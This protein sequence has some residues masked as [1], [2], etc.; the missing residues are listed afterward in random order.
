MAAI[1][2][3]EVLSRTWAVWSYGW[4]SW[5]KVNI[6]SDEF[7]FQKRSLAELNPKIPKWAIKKP[8]MGT[9]TMKAAYQGPKNLTAVTMARTQLKKQEVTDTFSDTEDS[10]EDLTKT[11]HINLLKSK[12]SPLGQTH[13]DRDLTEQ[14]TP[15]D[16]SADETIRL[17]T[18]TYAVDEGPIYDPKKENRHVRSPLNSKVTNI[19]MTKSE[20]FKQDEIIMGY[21][22]SH[23][24]SF[25]SA[26]PDLDGPIEKLEKGDPEYYN[27]QPDEYTKE[28]VT[29]PFNDEIS[30]IDMEPTATHV[31]VTSVAN[32]FTKRV[33]KR[34]SRR[35]PIE[36][37]CDGQVFSTYSVDVSVGGIF[38]EEPLPRWV[39]GYSKVRIR[40][41]RSRQVVELTC[42]IVENQKPKQRFRIAL[43]PLKNRKDEDHLETWIKAA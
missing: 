36:I 43:L 7:P 27:H 42:Y 38:L 26:E 9:A 2:S 28:F 37:E 41:E 15:R 4:A 19:D 13:A 18:S 11:D 3:A 6:L 10:N 32:G 21:G 31:E 30:N 12:L 25:N 20:A 14:L 40:N 39:S 23:Q 35:L 24:P 34:Y 17:G 8:D 1:G 5:K 29:S 22:E 33:H 16:T